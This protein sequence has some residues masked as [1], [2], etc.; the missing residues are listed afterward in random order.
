MV[1]MRRT[2]ILLIAAGYGLSFLVVCLGT[3][4]AGAAVAEHA[5][6]EGE[7][8]FRAAAVDC[9]SVM[10][11]ASPDG[12]VAGM[13]TLAVSLSYANFVSGP[14]V[15]P[16]VEPVTLAPSPPLVLRI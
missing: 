12:P 15:S 5:C 9:C 2:S 10:P 1:A 6:C 3:C 4:F 7:D 11:G 14:P 13:A 16:L 8:G